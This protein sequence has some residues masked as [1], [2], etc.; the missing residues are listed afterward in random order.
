M[1]TL[2]PTTAISVENF[3]D[4]ESMI[5]IKY[6]TFLFTNKVEGYDNVSVPTF[7]VLDDYLDEINGYTQEYTFSSDEYS[8]YVQAPRLLSD[9]LYKNQELFPILLRINDIYDEREF[10]MHTIKLLSRSDMTDVLSQIYNAN[11]KFINVYNDR[12]NQ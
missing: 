6:T 12:N 11:K 3:I 9:Y 2:K 7:N 8:K 4:C 5:P 1:A 10:T